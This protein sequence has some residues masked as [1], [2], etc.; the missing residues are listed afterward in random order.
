MDTND[1][2]DLVILSF[3][4]RE[5]ERNFANVSGPFLSFSG[6]KK[7]LKWSQ[8]V[9]NVHANGQ[10]RLIRNVRAGTQ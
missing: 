9:K 4:K 7:V 10:K 3:L 1:T 2:N 6:H 5:H 8:T